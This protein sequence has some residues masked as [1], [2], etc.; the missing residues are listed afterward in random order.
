MS[1]KRAFVEHGL[2]VRSVQIVYFGP[3]PDRVRSCSIR[4]KSDVAHF[5]VGTSSL[6]CEGKA[7]CPR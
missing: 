7:P 2:S 6:R 5:R 4:R 1:Q 3:F